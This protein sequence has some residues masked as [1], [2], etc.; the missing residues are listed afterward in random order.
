MYLKVLAKGQSKVGVLYSEQ[1]DGIVFLNCSQSEFLLEEPHL[2]DHF[3][4]DRDAAADFINKFA[5]LHAVTEKVGPEVRH[6]L[7]PYLTP[8]VKTNAA[9]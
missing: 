6:W 3:G 1:D 2:V 7:L 4:G 9:G 8:H 5:G